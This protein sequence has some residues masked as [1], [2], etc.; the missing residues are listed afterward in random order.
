MTETPTF[1]R[2]LKQRR[3]VLALTQKDVAEQVGCAVITI[4]KIEA[5][6]L[7]PSQQ[8]AE[9]LANVLAIP[10]PERDAFYR[11]ARSQR[12]ASSGAA[13]ATPAPP[14]SDAP[15]NPYKGIRAFNEADAPDFFG[16]AALVER[17]LERL[18]E[19]GASARFLA[20]VGPSG[21]GKSSVV[22][23][24]LL[25][26]LRQGRLP[27]SEHWVM[28]TCVPGVYPLEE[29]EAALLRVAG[30]PPPSLLEQL[31]A[32]TRGLARAVRRVLPD[33]D[34]V[35]LVLVIDQFEELFTLVTD[36]QLRA[37]VLASLVT[38]M[39]G[40]RPRL[41]VVITLRA[42]FYDRPLLY[43]AFGELVR[44]RTE[45]VLPLTAD[46]LH[47]AIVCPAERVG[48]SVDPT[49]V[50]TIV[51]DVGTQP[52]MLPLLQ[53]T[54]TA[55]FERRQGS[56]LTRAAYHAAGGVLHTLSRRAEEIY[57][58]LND[59]EQAAARQ[60][61]LRLITPGD[62]TDDTRRR[63]HLSEFQMTHASQ[64]AQA[65]EES[66]VSPIAESRSVAPTAGTAIVS[67]HASSTD[68][69]LR[70]TDDG[71]NLPDLH[72]PGSEWDN[73]PME[74]VID[75][76]GQARLLTFD[77]HPVT[78]EPTVEVAH[79]AL[80]RVWERLRGWIDAVREH[81]RVQRRLALA[82]S[83]WVQA[84]RHPDFLANGGQLAQFESLLGSSGDETGDIVALSTLEWEFLLASIAER[85]R[86]HALE[87]TRQER[88]LALA[89]ESAQAQRAAAQ[90]LRWLVAGLGIFLVVAI[91]LALV[92]LNQ[93]RIAEES[94]TR[95]E[96]QRL[97]TEARAL[98]QRGASAE[99][100]ALLALQSLRLQPTPQGEAALDLALTLDY[101]AQLYSG[102]TDNITSLAITPDGHLLL[103]GSYDRT[104]RLWDL[105]TN[106]L[107]QSFTVAFGGITSV[108]VSPD[109]TTAITGGEDGNIRL[110]TVASGQERQ[111]LRGHRGDVTGLAFTPDG[112]TL[113]SGSAD[114]T[115][116]VWNLA[117]GRLLQTFR[118]HTATITSVALS[119]D[120]NQALTGSADNTAQLWDTR[121]TDVLQ[122]F[123]DHS[124][125]ITSV[126]L[127]PDGRFALVGSADQTAYLWDIR[128][129]DLVQTYRGHTDAVT[130]VAF[131]PD[132]HLALTGSADATARIWDIQAGTALRTLVGGAVP[133]ASA[134]FMP[135]AHA[136]LVGSGSVVRQWD[137]TARS[138]FA[139][140][141]GHSDAV[142]SVA[143]SP[144][145]RLALTGSADATARV[146]DLQS[147]QTLYTFTDHTV[148]VRQVAFAPDGDL[149][150][151]VGE[152]GT[153][154]L[155]ESRH[156]TRM[157]TLSHPA[158][159]WDAVFAP[160]GDRILTSSADGTI[161]LWDG[162]AGMVL[163]QFYSS[164]LN[165]IGVTF[166]SGGQRILASDGSA[167][168]ETWSVQ[169]E[170]QRSAVELKH[171]A[172]VAFIDPDGSFRLTA[173]SHAAQS[174]VAFAPDQRYLLASG[175]DTRAR[176]WEVADGQLI[177]TFAGHTDRVTGV[178]F[179]LQGDSIATG[180]L[181]RTA[182]LWDMTT[183]ATVRHLSGHTGSVLA[184][185]F[186]P[187]GRAV[188]TGSSD[189]TARLWLRDYRAGVAQLCDW[190]QRDLL[191]SER[192]RYEMTT[193]T[194]TCSAQG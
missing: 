38:A 45:V 129:G 183:G 67:G 118:A 15:P 146:W 81:L 149:L 123:G 151:T 170:T 27:G 75:R 89:H 61:F 53:Y 113:L 76:Y 13:S 109:G 17:L 80:L 177:E 181:D 4:K 71:Y 26:A 167:S 173:S 105:T 46:E 124:A 10:P 174:G 31:L 160:D 95:V 102:H 176:L 28:A 54:L 178:A 84:R 108:A 87:H 47:E 133:V 82:A 2:I 172:R 128:S 161:R 18:A 162:H 141:T 63:V 189:G 73:T 35:E 142:T 91:V 98:A 24:G 93:R 184:V 191:P 120:G 97:A 190:L 30:N 180:S 20:V 122:T 164:A 39:D 145:G 169:E 139:P 126:A 43:E 106:D 148:P 111:V 138:P 29:I 134:A 11:L 51:R 8:I 12:M 88:E 16:R 159:V 185:A 158:G 171:K 70:G 147:G 127:S 25:P 179:A 117:S 41:R 143:L 104:A 50:A 96:A 37:H 119:P 33:D 42:D 14:V 187:D 60:L 36:E 157:G 144:D 69:G 154:Y 125:A 86:Q 56:T 58:G 168:V 65:G 21:S 182:R 107:R 22:R 44:R 137:I 3:K 64:R 121:S 68:D 99:L 101:P 57:A 112:R 163:Q 130:S 165:P 136:V 9:R 6:T 59:A 155:W 192:A 79:E 55:L 34:R 135:D 150:L 132:E 92:A 194:P 188:L 49:L 78:R 140:L 74:R 52:G 48:L 32:D 85:D 152:D 103:T 110:W 116:R 156:G 19:E 94:F 193:A 90:R 115:A 40:P 77:Q 72:M 131:S 100:V 66:S 7:R 153:V 175:S 114:R 186:T 62:G 23:A 1:G 5:D 166:G 83:A